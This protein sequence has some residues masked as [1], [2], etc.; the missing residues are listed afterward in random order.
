M[1]VLYEEIVFFYSLLYTKGKIC[2]TGNKQGL[3]NVYQTETK[4]VLR[5]YTSHKAYFSRNMKNIIVK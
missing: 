5:K 3:I 2:I 4:Y 1:R